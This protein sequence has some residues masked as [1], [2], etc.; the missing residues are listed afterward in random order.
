MNRLL[1]RLAAALAATVGLWMFAGGVSQAG[2]VRTG[3]Q[4]GLATYYGHS[5]AYTA[6][7]RT[8]PFGSLVHVTNRKNGRSVLV[9]IV[10]R[11]PMAW[12]GRL[13]DLSL[14]AAHALD[15]VQTGVVPVQLLVQR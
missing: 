15:M 9:R 13:I 8:L 1:A 7:H 10:D 14:G 4:Y 3:Q 11:G 6:A 12:T 5:F 2:Q